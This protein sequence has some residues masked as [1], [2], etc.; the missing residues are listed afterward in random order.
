[1]SSADALS[2]TIGP[3]AAVR[4]LPKSREGATVED[5]TAAAAP[6][7]YATALEHLSDEFRRLDLL[8]CCRL[9][10]QRDETPAN[11]LQPFRGL[12]LT[13]EEIRA[14]LG[15]LFDPS[16]DD[17]DPSADDLP[18][19]DL[20]AALGQMAC[21]IQARRTAS[22]NSGIY[23]SLPHL[24][25]LFQL[26]AFEEQCLLICLAPELNR[27]YEKLYA[28]LQDDVTRKKPSVDLVLNLLC[29]TMGEKVAARLGFDPESP[30]LNYRLLQMTDD[31]PDGP[32]PLLSRLLKLDDRTVNFLLGFEQIDARLRSI[33]RLVA[34]RAQLDQV[35]VGEQI[36]SRIRRFIDWHRGEE[37]A[38]RR[39]VVFHFVGPYGSGKRLLAEAICRELE[40]PLLI[41]ESDKIASGQV[42]FEE[43]LWLL[44]REAVL[45]SAAL[46]LGDFDCLLADDKRSSRLKSLLQ[47]IQA[48]GLTVFLLG[49]QP[50][51]PLGLFNDNAFIDL[52]I[53]MPDDGIRKRLWQSHLNGRPSLAT[54]AEA[55]AL[56]SK[57]RFT[58]G[59][60]QDA[61]AAARN[62][63]RWRWPDGGQLTAEDLRA[64][65]RAQADPRL[66]R[67][68]RKIQP[69]HTW[70]DLVLPDDALAQLGEMCQ[71]VDHGYRVLGEW[72]FGGKLSTGK[73]V[74][75]LF[76]GPSGT[77]KTMAADIL[78]NQLGLDLYKIDLS[79]IV[80]KYIGETEK[81]LDAIFTAAENGNAILFFDEADSLFGKRS[82]VRDS[83]DRY[84]NIESSYLLQ[85]ME[86]YEGVAILATNLRQNLDEAFVRRL[87]FTIHFPFPDEAHRR[88]IWLGIWPDQIPLAKDV[89][90][91]F[92]ARQFKLSG[93]SIKNVA[94]AA[95]FFAAVEGGDVNMSHLLQATRR[96]FQ[97]LGKVLTDFDLEAVSREL[98]PNR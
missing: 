10:E 77:G 30:L 63:A 46:C 14:L 92:L 1:V 70:N 9:P 54:D 89:D 34:A 24:V 97:K 19:Q 55:G 44:G 78:A 15:N 25:Q 52:E 69:I 37:Q 84:A 50:W 16:S 85:K 57:F 13:E 49:S 40:L 66:N 93:G 71:R 17:A 91:D 3:K 20:Q 82:E 58:P 94:L 83:H 56:A 7:A 90:L 73:G 21:H 68:A 8:I 41:A 88:R 5:Q 32:S 26:T 2:E 29:R 36:R 43:A 31:A 74:N 79:Q 47:V 4:S 81:N 33:A 11:P 27:K 12:V 62:L 48:F 39:Q 87:A 18:N 53:P 95:A 6:V 35:P 22:F 98:Q 75:A 38:G 42:P 80:S 67:L 76:A 61:V 86:E 96:E 51:E 45:Q 65:C 23:L 72:G 28:Y 60:I 64:A 59:Q